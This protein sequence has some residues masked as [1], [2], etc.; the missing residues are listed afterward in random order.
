MRISKWLMLWVWLLPSW[1]Q[2]EA[3]TVEATL[4]LYK[5]QEPGTQSYP[6]RILVTPEYVRF[7]D[8]H[9][10]SDYV[11]YE[12]LNQRISSVVHSNK[13]LSHFAVPKEMTLI[14]IKSPQIDKLIEDDPQAPTIDERAVKLLSISADGE[15]CL[16]SAVVPGFLP[17]VV[18]ALAEYHAVIRKRNIQELNT[19]PADLRT[20]CYLANQIFAHGSQ[21][22]FGFPVHENIRD[23]RKRILMDYRRQVVGSELFWLPENYQVFKID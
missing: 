10:G 4:V 20:P 17:E 22:D 14:S 15:E 11:L 9:N 3:Q 1:V 12:R 5:E 7:D 2:A 21:Y 13:T 8:G 23:G 16:S 18:E 6:V 19:L